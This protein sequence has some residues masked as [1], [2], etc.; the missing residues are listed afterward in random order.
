MRATR[1]L[2]LLALGLAVARAPARA[3]TA[4]SLIDNGAT[5]IRF[6]L[7]NP[8]SAAVVGGISGATTQLNGIDFRPA[9]GR[10]YGYS[11]AD[12]AIVVVNVNNGSTT[13]VSNPS[14]GSSSSVLG[15]DFNPV[16]DRLR[17]VNVDGQ[18][19][20]INV[21]DGATIVDGTLAY[22]AGDPN[23]GATPTITEVAYTNMDT[24]PATGTQLYYIDAGLGIL[25]TT[26][27][28][29][30]GVLDTVGSLGVATTVSNGFDIFTPTTG[31]NLAYAVLTETGDSSLYSID[32]ST[33]A[34]TLIGA[35]P[36]QR[37]VGLAIRPVPEPGTLASVCVGAG[38]VGLGLRRR[39]SHR[40]ARAGSAA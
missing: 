35:L 2:A 17:M 36:F 32:L 24:D 7:S 22:A 20:R 14:A 34:A 33:G 12:N 3:Q 8:G 13:F 29:N 27:N 16:P 40:R 23:E 25:A 31:V 15:M 6:D 4:Y 37:V 5:L 1:T 30:G 39:R 9:D 26:S 21:D 28:P 38:L 11:F 10:L 19:L 18:N